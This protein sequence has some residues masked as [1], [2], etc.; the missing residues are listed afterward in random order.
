[1]AAEAVQQAENVVHR[2]LALTPVYKLHGAAVLQIDA[3]Y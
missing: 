3:R 1:M 2:E